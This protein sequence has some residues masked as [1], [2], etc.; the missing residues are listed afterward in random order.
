MV[1]YIK[2]GWI[3]VN[4]KLLNKNIMI[5]NIV[6]KVLYLF[7]WFVVIILLCFI[8]MSW[9]F[10]IKNF[11]MMIIIIFYIVILLGIWIIK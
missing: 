9:I 7:K 11:F 8:V 1:I 2:L 6:V 4:L 10:V 5:V 3:S